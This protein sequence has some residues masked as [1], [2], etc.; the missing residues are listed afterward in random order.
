ML[1]SICEVAGLCWVWSQQRPLEHLRAAVELFESQ[2]S[3][4][5]SWKVS[6]GGDVL[7]KMKVVET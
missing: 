2:F 5:I 4:G 1:V 6:R 7:Q 3:V